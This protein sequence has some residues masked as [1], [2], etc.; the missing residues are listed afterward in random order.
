MTNKGEHSP[1]EEEQE[2]GSAMVVD[3]TNPHPQP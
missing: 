3:I 2:T 1:R